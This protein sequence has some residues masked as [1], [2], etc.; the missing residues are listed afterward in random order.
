MNW[1]LTYAALENEKELLL[2]GIIPRMGNILGVYHSF[3]SA[4]D[5]ADQDPH[6]R[7]NMFILAAEINGV[8][9]L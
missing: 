5:A 3:E 4:M 1:F 9:A 8:Q 6:I 7:E 2:K